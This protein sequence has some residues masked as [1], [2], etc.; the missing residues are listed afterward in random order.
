[1]DKLECHKGF[2]S[3]HKHLAL[4]WH[5][6]VPKFPGR[7]ML[8]WEQPWQNEHS[9]IKLT[10]SHPRKRAQHVISINPQGSSQVKHT[11]H[12]SKC[13]RWMSPSSGSLSWAAGACDGVK[14]AQVLQQGLCWA[15][16]KSGT[17]SRA[18][19]LQELGQVGVKPTGCVNLQEMLG[20]QGGTWC[21]CCL[22][23][24]CVCHGTGAAQL[25]LLD[26]C[27]NWDL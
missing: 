24:S 9:G 25:G 7:R 21:L 13:S 6:G 1:M 14:S 4:S 12:E 10:K 22:G 26:A 19:K 27:F 8:S 11:G 18:A 16:P 23:A 17:S 2:L 3:K 5:L 20:F 15:V